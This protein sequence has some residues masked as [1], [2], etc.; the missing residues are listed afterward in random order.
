MTEI[1]ELL[2]LREVTRGELENQAD[3][4]VDED[5][6]YEA[7]GELALCVFEIKHRPG[8]ARVQERLKPAALGASIRRHD[9][10]ACETPI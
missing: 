2:A 7:L 5:V 4:S 1:A 6:G 3:A 10:L 8:L 9:W